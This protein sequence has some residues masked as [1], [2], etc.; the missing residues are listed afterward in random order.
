MYFATADTDNTIHVWD[1]VSETELAVLNSGSTNVNLAWN[2]DSTQLMSVS[3]ASNAN[4]IVIWDVSTMN[5]V[6]HLD[7]L[8]AIIGEVLWN[9]ANDLIAVGGEE[10]I[11]WNPETNEQHVISSRLGQEHKRLAWSPNGVYLAIGTSEGTIVWNINT[12]QEVAILDGN[13]SRIVTLKWSPN[14]EMLAVSGSLD[15]HADVKIW[16]TTSWQLEHQLTHHASPNLMFWD[17]SSRYLLTQTSNVRDESIQLWDIST[18][19]R[20]N[21]IYEHF[22]GPSI[23]GVAWSPDSSQL[24]VS[25]SGSSI[26]HILDSSTGRILDTYR[27]EYPSS[28]ID[29]SRSGLLA[30]STNLV[31]SRSYQIV[32]LDWETRRELLTTQGQGL[33]VSIAW[34]TQG[35]QLAFVVNDNSLWIVDITTG[36]TQQFL[37]TSEESRIVDVAWSPDDTQIALA[38]DSLAGNGRLPGINIMNAD[39]GA[40]LFQLSS[41]DRLE[42]L[43]M[44]DIAWSPS[45]GVIV[46]GITDLGGR[47]TMIY[48]DV[49]T[50]EVLNQRPYSSA[51]DWHPSGNYLALNVVP[52][53]TECCN[54]E[55]I[56]IVDP[57]GI[58]IQQTLESYNGDITLLSWSPE[59]TM[60]ASASADGTIHIW[61]RQSDTA[62]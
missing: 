54:P 55:D 10:I 46:G 40:L 11:L 34:N 44:H 23:N 36:E 27:T 4:E 58:N 39:N 29:L 60:L 45:G 6:A 13:Q 24:L 2:Q 5:E 59:G 22:T 15:S 28:E 49:T 48:W 57:T 26:I 21:V 8:D 35:T 20:S 38:G 37:R 52:N 25:P 32:I 61:E 33:I 53:A 16:N 7:M 3:R 1:A 50:G 41:D 18:G 47:G 12:E 56:L 42:G 30:V 19:Q 31:E 51:F 14:G 9:P 62:D 43:I 17:S